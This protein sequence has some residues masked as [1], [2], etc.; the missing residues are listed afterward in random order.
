M[1][2]LAEDGHVDTWRFFAVFD[3]ILTPKLSENE[4]WRGPKE[5]VMLANLVAPLLTTPSRQAGPGFLEFQDCILI[6]EPL[7]HKLIYISSNYRHVRK[8]R[9]SS[10]DQASLSDQLAVRM[11]WLGFD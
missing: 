5:P 7:A 4:A 9:G 6:H 2:I 3:H 11:C 10:H 1:D 8:V